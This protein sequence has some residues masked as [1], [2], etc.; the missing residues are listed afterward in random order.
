ML[1]QV[2]G[3]P[4]SGKTFSMRNLD[5][6]STFII[7]SDGSKPPSWRG[8]KLQ[9]N[10]SNKNYAEIIDVPTVK[11]YIQ[12]IVERRPEIKVIIID[13]LT[14]LMEEALIAD[15]SRNQLEKY[16]NYSDTAFDLFSFCSRLKRGDDD[17]LFIIFMLHTDTKKAVDHLG[18]EVLVEVAKYAGFAT[19]KNT[20][21]KFSNY[22]LKTFID[23]TE[24]TVADRFKLLTQ[25]SG[26]DEIRSVEGVLPYMMGNDL[27]EVL[28]LI[29]KHD[30]CLPAYQ[31]KA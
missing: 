6:K 12:A 24:E 10:V 3:A 19:A 14:L 31:D 5:P 7:N 22:V 9:Y 26:K 11:S 16:R 29:R 17:D 28:N 23:M 8:S 25:S 21:T 2:Q 30:L 13:T 1:I 18:Q 15:K 20:L 27:N 4:A